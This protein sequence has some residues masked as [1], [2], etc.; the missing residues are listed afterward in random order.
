M[1]KQNS[2]CNL[3]ASSVK[4]QKGSLP[5]SLTTVTANFP[6]CSPK[7]KEVYQDHLKSRNRMILVYKN[8]YHSTI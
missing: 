5:N 7:K 6:D 3:R 4:E 8:L 2:L 1:S